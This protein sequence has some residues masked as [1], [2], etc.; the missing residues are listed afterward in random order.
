M[1]ETWPSV[2]ERDPGDLGKPGQDEN[3]EDRAACQL[4]PP[5][6][7]AD[8][9]NLG[10]ESGLEP[11]HVRPESGL[12]PLHV[13][14]EAGL[15]LLHVRPEAGHLRPESGLE[16]LHVRP[17]AGLD[18]LQIRPEAGHL[19]PESGLEPLQIGLRG[20]TAGDAGMDR[21]RDRLRLLVLQADVP[22]S[23]DLGD[24]VE[25]R[26][27]HRGLPFRPFP[28]IAV[29]PDGRQTPDRL[30]GASR[31]PRLDHPG[32]FPAPLGRIKPGWRSPTRDP[33]S[34]AASAPAA[35]V[36]SPGQPRRMDRPTAKECKTRIP[37]CNLVALTLRIYP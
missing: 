28:I 10:T 2:A 1:V 29:P 9:G 26:L 18:L 32:L 7:G 31:N 15:E 16:P 14:P 8:H 30:L 35:D 33:S 3:G 37:G 11:L 6:V 25:G 22:Q 13:R 27:S 12:E 20:D 21:A 23:L 4:D 34:G 5:Q 36:L 17:E 19:R 24:R